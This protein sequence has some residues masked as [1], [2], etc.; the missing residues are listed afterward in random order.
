MSDHENFN[1]EVHQGLIYSGKC[2]LRTSECVNI[3][4]GSASKLKLVR[5]SISLWR[6]STV[7]SSSFKVPLI[8][9]FL[10]RD[11]S[12]NSRKIYPILPQFVLLFVLLL[13]P[14]LPHS[15]SAPLRAPIS[16]SP[17]PPPPPF[18]ID[19]SRL[20]STIATQSANCKDYITH[21]EKKRTAP[22]RRM[23]AVGIHVEDSVYF[24]ARAKRKKYFQLIFNSIFMLLKH[25]NRTL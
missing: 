19:T 22:V 16:A 10:V 25:L 4:C 24:K 7:P 9:E 21:D 2:F 1:V 15:S 12:R 18:P 11:L 5:Y 20:L 13:S 23:H 6:A 17:P 3:H 14:L 8:H